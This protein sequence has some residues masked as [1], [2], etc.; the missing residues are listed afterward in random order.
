MFV[1]FDWL[2]FYQPF[3]L[4]V[5]ITLLLVSASGVIAMLIPYAAEIYPV[6][7]RGSGSGLVAAGS[8]F[9]GSKK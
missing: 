7:L 6:Q 3:W 9:G 8:K 4:S 2:Q 5:A 1:L